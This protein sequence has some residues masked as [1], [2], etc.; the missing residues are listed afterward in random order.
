MCWPGPVGT[1]TYARSNPYECARQASA[2][3]SSAGRN[4]WAN[5]A[6]DSAGIH[7][8]MSKPVANGRIACDWLKGGAS[9]LVSGLR[10]PGN[11]SAV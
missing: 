8:G 7:R 3:P 11:A 5:L 10:A 6:F 1:G 2:Q 4:V 9:R